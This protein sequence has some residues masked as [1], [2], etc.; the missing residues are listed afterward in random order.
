MY[1]I[2][3]NGIR[4]PVVPD[5]F[6][7]KY[8]GNNKT[9]NLINEAEVNQIKGMKLKEISF[10]LLLPGV[11]YPF[12]YYDKDVNH[13]DI[14]LTPQYF[15][16]ELKKMKR[17]KKPFKFKLIRNNH[18]G[19]FMW[20]NSMEVT[21]ENYEVTESAEELFD[22][23]VSIE[24]KQYV[25]FGVKRVKV[26]KKKFWWSNID[27]IKKKKIPSSYQTKKGDTLRVIG[28]KVYGKNTVNNA[29]VLYKKN[30]KEIDKALKSK[31]NGKFSKRIYTESL[32]GGMK[33]KVPGYRE[34]GEVVEPMKGVIL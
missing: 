24:L 28:K 13:K 18:T 30:K 3:M 14:F 27:T 4:F 21:L 26:K 31:W 7:M 8:H 19:Q 15:L 5:K 32:P 11:A 23:V 20:D 29:S 10:D 1:E 9:I 33:L 16:D 22:I 2:W 34:N 17:K 25:K 6:T 12:A